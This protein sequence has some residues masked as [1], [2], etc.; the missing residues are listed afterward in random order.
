MGYLDG[1]LSRTVARLK[2]SCHRSAE[3]KNSA[4][5]KLTRRKLFVQIRGMPN[6]GYSIRNNITKPKTKTFENLKALI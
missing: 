3:S 6:N 1:K 4:L 5:I 2:N